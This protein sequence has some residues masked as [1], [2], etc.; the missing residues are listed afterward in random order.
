MGEKANLG[1]V[2]FRFSSVANFSISKIALVGNNDI[3]AGILKIGKNLIILS[4][5]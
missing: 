2:L 1:L 4:S 3:S 5:N